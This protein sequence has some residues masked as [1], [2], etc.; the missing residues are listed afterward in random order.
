MSVYSA[1]A[2]TAIDTI[3]GAKT[4][5]LNTFVTEKKVKE[6][7]QT[8]VDAQ[9]LFAKEMVNQVDAFTSTVQTAFEKAFKFA[10]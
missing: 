6:P 5:F 10:K 1:Q 9:T 3:Q 7:L 2:I 8:F 4:T